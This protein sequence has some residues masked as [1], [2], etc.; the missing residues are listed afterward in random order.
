ML[1]ANES[2][3]LRSQ[4]GINLELFKGDHN[5]DIIFENV[6]RDIDGTRFND[7]IICI[8]ISY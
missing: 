1:V 7:L 6:F 5:A 4:D 8:Y 2:I 3:R